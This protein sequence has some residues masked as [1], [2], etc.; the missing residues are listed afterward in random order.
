M[1]P[2]HYVR[3]VDFKSHWHTRKF[4]GDRLPITAQ[5]FF[6]EVLRIFS[7]REEDGTRI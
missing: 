1:M 3:I 4:C 5:C 6:L 2:L 7:N